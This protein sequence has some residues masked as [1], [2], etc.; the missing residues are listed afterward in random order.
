MRISAAEDMDAVASAVEEAVTAD[1]AVSNKTRGFHA[2]DISFWNNEGVEID[3][4]KPIRVSITSE[5]IK[6]AVEDTSTAPVV[7]HV[8]DKVTDQTSADTTDA[9]VEN[10]SND[11]G[12][13][14][15]ES[16]PETVEDS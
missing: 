12:E 13:K 14:N 11:S 10:N 3:P 15:T 5:S 7:V 2:V 4:L 6:Q 16:I 8:T 9:V 1:D